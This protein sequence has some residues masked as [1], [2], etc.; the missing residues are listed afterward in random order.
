[1]YCIFTCDTYELC[2]QTHM[3]GFLGYKN[4]FLSYMLAHEVSIIF[5]TC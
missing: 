2:I 3:A 5:Q 4:I 1:M